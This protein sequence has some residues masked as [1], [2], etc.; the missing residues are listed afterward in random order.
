MRGRRYPED[1]NIPPPKTADD[2]RL[3]PDDP[4]T[5][6]EYAGSNQ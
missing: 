2:D 3:V 6:T 1:Y 5:V 4:L